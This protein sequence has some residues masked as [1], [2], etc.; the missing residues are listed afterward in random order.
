M[1][2][3]PRGPGNVD[4]GVPFALAGSTFGLFRPTPDW[5]LL[6]EMC[7]RVS[8]LRT[9]THLGEEDGVRVG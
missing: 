5:P 1:R 2:R 9:L 3:V 4:A 7:P 6:C 8:I